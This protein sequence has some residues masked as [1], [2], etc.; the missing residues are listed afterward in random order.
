M[1]AWHGFNVVI[2]LSG[3][4]WVNGVLILFYKDTKDFTEKDKKVIKGIMHQVSTALEEAR[5]TGIQ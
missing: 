2:P 4:A 5:F 1:A 3:R